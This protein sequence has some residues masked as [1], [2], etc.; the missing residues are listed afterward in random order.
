VPGTYIAFPNHIKDI[1]RA[2]DKEIGGV[3]LFSK[4]EIH[5]DRKVL[6]ANSI[7]LTAGE[8]GRVDWSRTLTTINNGSYMIFHT[9]PKD[10]PGYQGYSSDDLILL[11]RYSL[12]TYKHNA[13]IHFCLSTG[14][15][16]HFTF[17]DPVVITVI[18]TLMK[19]LKPIVIAKFPGLGITDTIFQDT[20]MMFF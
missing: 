15:D 14:K 11:F 10:N 1:I 7:F 4:P 13:P 5:A 17:V 9:H 20:F 12:Q 18:R 6:L 2:T 3:I 19:M 8:V 16:I